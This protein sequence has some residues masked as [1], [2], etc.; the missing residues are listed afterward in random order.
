MPESKR[1]FLL[2][3]SPYI[4]NLMSY[5]ISVPLK[6]LCICMKKAHVVKPVEGGFILAGGGLS[7]HQPAAALNPTTWRTKAAVTEKNGA[8]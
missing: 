4:A 5:K 2:M 7:L 1:F 8:K 3:S 6:N